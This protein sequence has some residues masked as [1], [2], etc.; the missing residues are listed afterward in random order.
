MRHRSRC[1]RARSAPAFTLIE[2]LVVIAIIAIL[3]GL[4]L[5]AVQ[6]V[7]EA[8]ARMSCQN[9]LKQIGLGLHNHESAFGYFPT[10]GA[11]SAALGITGVGFETMGWGYQLLPFIEQ[12][13][14]HR[15]GQ[16]Y[17]PWGWDPAIGSSMVEVPVKV[18]WCPSRTKRVSV[19]ASW[20]TVYAMS[21]YAGVMLEWGN[22]WQSVLPPDPN[23]PR[24]FQGIIAKGGHVRTDNPGLTQKYAAVTVTSVTDGTSN[25]IAL[26]EKAVSVRQYQ[27][28]ATPDWDWWEIPGWAHNSD[29]PNMRLAGNWIPLLADTDRNRIS[30]A[31]ANGKYW[32]PGFGSAHTGVVM[33]V[34]GDGSVRPVSMSVNSCGSATWS[35][36]SCVLYHLGGRADGWTIDPNGY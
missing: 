28:T 9:N 7:R 2:L 14:L 3:L 12:E 30:W 18:Y 11:E 4:L 13:N 20:G 22:Q 17:G 5:P 15:V 26:M 1:A 35:D 24:T 29:W 16:Q 10:S 33:A 34:F 32:E 31:T 6:K 25:T 8:A 23:E 19:P 27:P 21:D 36:A